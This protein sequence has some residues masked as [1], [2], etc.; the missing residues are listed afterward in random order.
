VACLGQELLVAMTPIV[1]GS[2]EDKARLALRMCDEEDTQLLSRDE[3]EFVLK[4]VSKTL[5]L[6]GDPVRQL[7]CHIGQA[8][9]Q[10]D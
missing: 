10:V 7:L 3:F 8:L 9:K 1:K 5:G 2:L 6:F 4:T